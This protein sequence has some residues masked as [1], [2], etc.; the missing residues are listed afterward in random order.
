MPDEDKDEPEVTASVNDTIVVLTKVVGREGLDGAMLL[1]WMDITS[2]MSAEKFSGMPSVT[3]AMDDVTMKY[4]PCHGEAVVVQAQVNRAFRT[5]MEVG[6]KVWAETLKTGVQ[7]DICRAYFTFVSLGPDKKKKKLPPLTPGT[8]SDNIRRYAQALERRNIRISRKKVIE[9]TFQV[10]LTRS[11]SI[12]ALDYRP[13]ST[14]TKRSVGSVTST[15]DEEKDRSPV[16]QARRGSIAF[17]STTKP[18]VLLSKEPVESYTESVE[19]VLPQHA[20]HMGNCFGGR[21]MAWMVD[22]ALVSATRFARTDMVLLSID[23]IS[24]VNPVMVGDR[25]NVKCQVNHSFHDCVEVLNFLIILNSI[26]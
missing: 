11:K 1:E 16:S 20:N 15:M 21:A 10:M 12:T 3:A 24:F 7:K 13:S 9:E 6:C 25:F 2:C 4:A 8:D 5:S 17:L 14:L 23:Q 19:M 22:C 18:E 26:A